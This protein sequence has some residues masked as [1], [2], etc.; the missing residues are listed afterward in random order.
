MLV[1]IRCHS[2]N[3]VLFNVHKYLDERSDIDN[4]PTLSSKEKEKASSELLNKYKYKL[5]CCRGPI[6]GTIESHKLIISPN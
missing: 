1:P 3:R 4:D 5:Y 2:C 6:M